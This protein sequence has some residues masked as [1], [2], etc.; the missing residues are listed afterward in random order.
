MRR[1]LHVGPCNTP[2]GMAKVIEILSENPPTGWQAETWQSHITSNIIGKFLHHRKM[3]KG[4]SR[5][6]KS[7]TKPDIVH[8]HTAADW[9]W[10]RK[11][12]Y[13]EVCTKHSVPCI[14]HIHSGNFTNWLGSREAPNAENFRKVTNSENC[15]VVV[16][17]EGWRDK[18]SKLIGECIV[19]NNP[20]D[21]KLKYENQSY[22]RKHQLL[23][24]G[25][26]DAVKGHQFAVDLLT[27]LRQEYDE[28]L[29]LIMTGTNRYSGDGL[30]SKSWVSEKEKLALMQQSKL[31]IMPSKYEG[32]PLVMLESLHCGLPCVVSENIMDLPKTVVAAKYNHLDDWFD[33]VTKILEEPPNTGE[34]HSAVS[35]LKIDSINKKWLSIYDSMID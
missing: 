16:L 32:Q 14:V 1:V 33:K 11:S 21:P 35:H 4:F 22:Q 3:L 9:S 28:T 19:V 31:L 6:M 20:V 8:I 13:V 7:N 29:N 15:K 34:I 23:M 2:G 17:T 27:K 18:L 24:L 25:R 26:F 12:A 30:T 10:R 5:L